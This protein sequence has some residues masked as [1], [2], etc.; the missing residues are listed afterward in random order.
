MR[1]F[2]HSASFTVRVPLQVD[3][4]R[5]VHYSVIPVKFLVRRRNVGRRVSMTVLSN[6]PVVLNLYVRT[7]AGYI[8]HICSFIRESE[9]V[10]YLNHVIPA[11]LLELH[12]I[13]HV[14]SNYSTNVCFN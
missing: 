11:T 4:Y 13:K 6:L 12:R 14:D 9:P 3:T 1:I 8:Y 10:K 2:S 7:L 5:V